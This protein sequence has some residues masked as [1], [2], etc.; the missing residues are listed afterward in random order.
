MA[1]SGSRRKRSFW[2]IALW[3][4]VGLLALFLV[5]QFVPYGRD[6][7]TKAAPNPFQW[8]APAAEAIAR[9]SCY[10]CHSNETRWWWGVKIAPMSWL[11]Q[12]DIDGAQEAFS[13]SDWNGDL[14]AEEMQEAINDGMP[15]LQYTL[16]HPGA[17]LSDAEKQT[18]VAGF[19]ASL[20]ASSGGGSTASPTPTATAT[21]SGADADAIIASRCGSCHPTDRALQF[22]ASSAADAQAL[23][24]NMIQRGA[25]VTP[26]EER[27][28]IA[29]FTR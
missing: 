1:R 22:R 18:L 27:A 12:R 8:N 21:S 9:E 15:P 10:D 16:L 23:I 24:D 7:S 19:Q 25:S 29:Y 11:A 13:F 26:E 2:K 17:K 3:T 28:L 20:G 5:I 6:H 4:I 14:T